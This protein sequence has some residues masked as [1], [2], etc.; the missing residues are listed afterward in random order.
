[1]KIPKSVLKAAGELVDMYG[2]SF[3]YLGKDEGRDVYMFKFPEDEDTGFPFVY[4]C[5]GENV[6]E[7]T[8]FEALDTIRLF[9]KD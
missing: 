2:S 3:K 1:M 4:L 8:G 6:M 9:I 5:N 7:L